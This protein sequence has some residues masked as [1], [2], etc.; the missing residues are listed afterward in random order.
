MRNVRIIED[1]FDQIKEA[2]GISSTDEIVTTFIKAEEQNYSLYNYVNRLNQE[3]DILEENNKEIKNE[4]E[5]LKL[6]QEMD[7]EQREKHVQDLKDEIDRIHTKLEAAENEKT[8]LGQELVAIQNNVEK[9][10][11]LFKQSRFFLSVASKMSY[12]E[13]TAFTQNNILSFLAELEEY[14]SSLITYVA[15]K[16]DEPHAAISAIPLEKLNK[17]DWDKKES[18]KEAPVGV[19]INKDKFGLPDQVN[20]DNFYNIKNSKELYKKF[21]SMIDNE[22]I[23]F[24]QQQTAK[25]MQNNH[26]RNDGRSGMD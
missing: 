5:R 15:F 13:G 25:Q 12:E 22:Q 21:M 23:S 11:K 20:D 18:P 7:E 4:I 14:I 3:T 8:N 26:L 6:T 2:T 9:M 16:R 19:E 24:I 1:A 10:V 17:K